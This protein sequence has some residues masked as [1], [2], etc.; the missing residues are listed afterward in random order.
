MDTEYPSRDRG[1]CGKRKAEGRSQMMET[2]SEV[3]DS[4]EH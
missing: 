4:M 3:S 1:T 2:W